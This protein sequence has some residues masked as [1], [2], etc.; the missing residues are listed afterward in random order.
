[1]ENVSGKV[2]LTTFPSGKVAALTMLYLEKQDLSNIT[3]EELADK[4]HEAYQ[5]INDRFK[6]IQKNSH[7][8]WFK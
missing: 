5:R 2:E 8:S 3:P 1:V 6:E 4:Y 7:K